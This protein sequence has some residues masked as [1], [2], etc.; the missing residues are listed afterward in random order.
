MPPRRIA[1][2]GGGLSGLTTAYHLTRL[3]PTSK[4]TLLDSASRVGGWIDSSIREIGFRDAEGVIRE[5]TVTTESGPRSIRP[6]G[7]KGAPGMLRLLRDLDM[8]DSII[9]VTHH[10]PSAK[11]RFLLDTSS[12]KLTALPSSPLS[13]LGPQPSLLKG[14]VPSALSEPFRTR[15]RLD[16]DPDPARGRGHD[17]SVDSFFRRR[18]GDKIATNLA[19]AMVHGIYATSSSQLSVRAA[20]P[21]LWDAEVKYGSVLIGMLRGVK[22]SEEKSLE[23]KE[24]DELG[25]LGRKRKEWSLYGL[26]GGLRSLTNRLLEQLIRDGKVDTRLGQSATAMEVVSPSSSSTATANADTRVVRIHTSSAETIECDHIISA[27]PPPVL[28]RLLSSVNSVRS[29]VT[30]NFNANPYTSVGVVNIIYPIPPHKIH[31]AGFGYLIPRPSTTQLNPHGILGVIFDSTAVPFSTSSNDVEGMVTKLT[32]MMGGPYWSTYQPT[33]TRPSDDEQLT[34]NAITHLN[35]IFPHLNKV[36]PILKVGR[37]HTNCI[38][39][40]L[41]GHGDRLRELHHALT[42]AA[43]SPSVAGPSPYNDDAGSEWRGRLS[44]VGNGYGGVGVNDCVYSA[45]E[46]V[47]ALATGQATATGLERWESWQ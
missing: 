8:L 11:N 10:H 46:V 43:M 3:L 4:I 15:R 47:K 32:V 28:S 26:R 16:P 13:L 38:P 24:W 34:H 19:S 42:P 40:Y 6:K 41:P 17:E 45:E 29:K 20:F 44:L 7:S 33:L 23:Q 27:L 35:G 37:I 21:I 2:L 14:L 39:T 22:S 18:F 9:P 5:G 30:S 1:V 36:E 31:P 12:N 25:E